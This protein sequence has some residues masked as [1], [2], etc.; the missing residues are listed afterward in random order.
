[1]AVSTQKH[2]WGLL[3]QSSPLPGFGLS[4][5]FTSVYLTAIILVP[6][7][8]LVMRSL[9]GGGAA[10]QYA[11]TSQRV[12]ASYRVTLTSAL[13][14]ALISAVFG[15]LVAWVLARYEFPGKRVVDAL[16]DLPFALPTAVAG[17]ALTTLY[18]EKGWIGRYLEPY[19]VHVVFTQLGIIVAMTF[20]GLPFVVRS[21]Q[22]V[23]EDIDESVEEAAASLGAHHG[24]IFFRIL[25]PTILP[26]LLTGTGMAF[27]RAVGE[28]GSVIFIAGNMPMRTEI[29]ALL[30][31][32][33][34]EEYD[35]EGAAA[36]AVVLL[37]LSCLVML[38]INLLQWRFQRGKGERV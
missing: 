26:A 33:K 27:A 7:I 21:V 22:P 17:I 35:Y 34:L 25:L 37:V 11:F 8:A 1:M 32:T 9:H 28:Y 10:F 15:I 2:S 19:D 36:I 30:I 20:V 29:T 23:L 31:V 5:G 6:L 16:I 38:G 24:H 18:I 13:A 14:A 12:L 4:L 3:R